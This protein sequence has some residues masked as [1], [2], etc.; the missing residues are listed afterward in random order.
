MAIRLTKWLIF[1]VA[2]ALV[3]LV[4][5]LLIQLNAG[6]ALHIDPV[7]AHGELLLITASLCGASC[8]ELFGS[9]SAYRIGKLLAGGA[10]ILLLSLAAIVF[11]AVVSA[12]HS[13]DPLAPT[14]TATLS[15]IL[16]ICAI[17]AC[18]SCIALSEG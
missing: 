6:S 12:H 18:G 1:S 16:F 5:R 2:L 8:G 15:L 10:A 13:A 9:S 11:G 4:F 17:I 3:P 7:L 14:R